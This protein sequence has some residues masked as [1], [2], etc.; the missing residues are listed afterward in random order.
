MK[1]FITYILLLIL[2][3]TLLEA[4]RHTST[5]FIYWMGMVSVFANCAVA[6]RIC[7]HMIVFMRQFSFR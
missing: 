3:V 6:L 7:A 5:H 2:S 1:L 4:G